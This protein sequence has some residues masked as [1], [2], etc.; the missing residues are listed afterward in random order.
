MVFE[1]HPTSLQ[2]H[3]PFTQQLMD[4]AYFHFTGS[5]GCRSDALAILRLLG[6]KWIERI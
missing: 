1:Q 5:T 4:P 6:K 3:P 2:Q